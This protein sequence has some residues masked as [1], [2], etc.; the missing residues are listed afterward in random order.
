MSIGVGERS[1]AGNKGC[2]SWRLLVR[3]LVGRD[4]LCLFV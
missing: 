1:E 2:G 4:N 3:V